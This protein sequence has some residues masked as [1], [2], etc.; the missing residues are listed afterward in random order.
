MAE[1]S[2][3]QSQQSHACS[4]LHQSLRIDI[5]EQT[6]SD[7]LTVLFQGVRGSLLAPEFPTTGSA[8]HGLRL[9]IRY[10]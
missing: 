6:R 7:L 2:R 3:T 8:D 1:K 10:Y 5:F 4:L 9:I